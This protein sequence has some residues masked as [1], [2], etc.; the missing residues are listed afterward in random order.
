AT[1]IA[2]WLV[3][4]G[5]PF[6]VAHEVAGACVRAC[7]EQSPAIELWE[8]TEGMY[9]GRASSFMREAVSYVHQSSAAKFAATLTVELRAELRAL[10]ESEGTDREQKHERLLASCELLEAAAEDFVQQAKLLLREGLALFERHQSEV[11]ESAGEQLLQLLGGLPDALS[12]YLFDLQKR[13]HALGYRWVLE[14]KSVAPPAV[15]GERPQ[16]L[17]AN[18]YWLVEWDERRGIAFFRRSAE[19]VLDLAELV[20]ENERGLAALR[21][22]A[23]CR[24]VVVDTR[25]APPRNDPE[26]ETAMRGMRHELCRNY[27]RVA[28]VIVTAVG[29]LQVVRLGRED[30]ATTLVTQSEDAAIQFAMGAS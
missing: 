16:V 21:A 8:L 11:L 6:R 1:D 28:V 13:M 22:V 20:R 23:G 25:Q 26:F 3:R 18:R 27:G 19:P 5:V 29:V 14:R 24:G 17:V 10:L 15:L 4:E 30:D 9:R 2:E 7:E 12:G